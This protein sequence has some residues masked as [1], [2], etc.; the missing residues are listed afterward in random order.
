MNGLPAPDSLAQRGLLGTLRSWLGTWADESWSSPAD[1]P[2]ETRMPHVHDYGSARVL[3]ADD[4]PVNLML[5]SALLESRG[6][7]ASVAADGAEAVALASEL[8]FDL[9]LMDLQMPILNGLEATEAIRRFEGECSRLPVPVV[10]YTSA[11]PGAKV[12][13]AYGMSGSLSKPCE[14]Q[15]L[16]RCLVQWCPSYCAAPLVPGDIHGNSGSQAGS[17]SFVTPY[18]TRAVEAPSRHSL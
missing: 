14:D 13:A 5:I 8:R 7:V 15:D 11:S 16:E 18:W 17:R 6:L 10:A 4:N 9:I 2:I 12:L 1:L 3:V